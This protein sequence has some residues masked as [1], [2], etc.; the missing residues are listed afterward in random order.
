[1]G[2]AFQQVPAQRKVW[3]DYDPRESIPCGLCPSEHEHL[4]RCLHVF[5][6]QIPDMLRWSKIQANLFGTQ[7]LLVF[8]EPPTFL[9]IHQEVL[10]RDCLE[11]RQPQL[12]G[13]PRTP[14]SRPF[15]HLEALHR[16]SRS[17]CGELQEPQARPSWTA[18]TA[19]SLGF[20]MQE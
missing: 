1:M 2:R 19:L 5:I 16:D 8:W 20:K 6:K 15:A 10:R 13:L 9:R 3:G 4:G 11:F 17:A 18:F 12:A 7:L 14:P